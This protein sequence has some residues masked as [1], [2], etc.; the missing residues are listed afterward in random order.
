MLHGLPLHVCFCCIVRCL[1]SDEIEEERSPRDIN[2]LLSLEE[3]VHRMSVF[4][5]FLLHKANLELEHLE[6]GVA[7]RGPSDT[8]PRGRQRMSGKRSSVPTPQ[9]GASTAQI[10]DPGEP[11]HPVTTGGRPAPRGKHVRSVS[12]MEGQAVSFFRHPPLP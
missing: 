4:K 10:S 11:A 1:A 9:K 12:A 2:F 6:R 8:R 3:I 7:T 5:H